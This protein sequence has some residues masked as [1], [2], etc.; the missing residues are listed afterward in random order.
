MGYLALKLAKIYPKIP[1]GRPRD[2][3][4][5]FI[6]RHDNGQAQLYSQD[7]MSNRAW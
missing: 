1:Q 5:R 7:Q 2:I 4:R 6:Y 3:I